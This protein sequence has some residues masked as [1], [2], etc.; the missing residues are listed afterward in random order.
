[1]M[2][3]STRSWVVAVST[4]LTVAVSLPSSAV[5]APRVKEGAPCRI[6]TVFLGVG[7]VESSRSPK[8][9]HFRKLPKWYKCVEGRW[10]DK[11]LVVPR[12]LRLIAGC[13]SGQGNPYSTPNPRATNGK[14]TASGTYQFLDSTWNHRF[15][16]SRAMYA[17]PRQQDLAA[18]AEYR[19]HGWWPW[20]ASRPC[21]GRAV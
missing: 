4:A 20:L 9:F 1:M 5:A 6:Q 3:S 15:G 16:V 8:T 12:I 19:R 14:S 17:T 7:S 18:I 13:E 11:R 2:P 10:Q 21:W